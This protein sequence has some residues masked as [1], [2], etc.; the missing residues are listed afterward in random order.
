MHR[1]GGILKRL[2]RLE[3][4]NDGSLDDREGKPPIPEGRGLE[5]PGIPD[6][7]RRRMEERMQEGK[8]HNGAVDTKNGRDP[9][10]DGGHAK[11]NRGT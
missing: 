9:A 11:A 5:R 3:R 1:M 6:E 8:R 10:A 7:I 2:E 4:K